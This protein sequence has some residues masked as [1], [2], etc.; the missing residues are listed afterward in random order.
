MN[1]AVFLYQPD[2]LNYL[3][4]PSAR[5]LAKLVKQSGPKDSPPRPHLSQPPA[6][7]LRPEG[8]SREGEPRGADASARCSSKYSFVRANWCAE[9]L[10]NLFYKPLTDPVV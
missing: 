7:I 2:V 1:P 4:P 8:V 5:N 10:S 6:L 9:S 3:P